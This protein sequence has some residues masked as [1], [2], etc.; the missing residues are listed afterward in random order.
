MKS[1]GVLN[2]YFG[3]F[4]GSNKI[5]VRGLQVRRSDAPPLVER[6][7]QEMLRL[8]AQAENRKEYIARIPEA[9]A[10]LEKYLQML[11]EGKVNRQELLITTRLS[12]DPL[13][14]RKPSFA[15]LAAR[16][17]AGRLRAGERIGY[18]ICDAQN[19]ISAYRVQ[20]A[21]DGE[22]FY[23]RDKYAE[24]LIRAAEP[25]LGAAPLGR[26]GAPAAP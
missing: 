2:R 22:L 19:R 24:Y 25:L 18:I 3:V 1:I 26:A 5:K 11:T 23:D 16:Q 21:G 8:F 12:K 7:Q 15:A 17:M 9:E 4:A 14:Y 10:I 20:A 13:L 6:M